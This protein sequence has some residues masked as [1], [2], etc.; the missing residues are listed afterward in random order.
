MDH[1]ESYEG[2]TSDCTEIAAV[3]RVERRRRWSDDQKL[4]ILKET[5]EPGAIMSLVARRH[6]INT[7]LLYTWRKQLLQG[8][9]SG[10][11]PV[12]LTPAPSAP[13]PSNGPIRVTGRAGLTVVIDR[14]V[15]RAALKLVLGVIEELGH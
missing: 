7:G 9:M 14:I 10:F 4:A 3:V 2:R 13:D 11:I 8:A 1:E 5:T 15:D 12:D 6:G